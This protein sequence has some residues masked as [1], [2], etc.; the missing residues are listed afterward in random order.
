M[1]TTNHIITD[2]DYAF[3][4]LQP[5]S[6]SRRQALLLAKAELNDEVKGQNVVSF[7][8]FQLFQSQNQRRNYS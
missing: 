8:F 2:F 1:I 3:K 6:T 5:K 7:H 4:A